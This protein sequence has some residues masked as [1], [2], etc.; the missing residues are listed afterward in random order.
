MTSTLSRYVM[1]NVL[2]TTLLVMLVLLTLSGLYI[3]ITQQD[4]IGVGSYSLE[5]AFLKLT[6]STIRDESANSADQM[7]Q[8]AKMWTSDDGQK[9]VLDSRRSFTARR[10]FL[11]SDVMKQFMLPWE[12]LDTYFT[13]LER[14]FDR[15]REGADR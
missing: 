2:G 14:L 3:F 10:S 4:E 12:D 8:F 7:R 6:G 1:R 9:I 5:D 13:G 11:N 15:Y